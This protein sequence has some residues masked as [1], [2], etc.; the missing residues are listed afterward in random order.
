MRPRRRA[1]EEQKPWAAFIAGEGVDAGRCRK[2]LSI[3]RRS[4]VSS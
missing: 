3:A 1:F 2:E 4:T